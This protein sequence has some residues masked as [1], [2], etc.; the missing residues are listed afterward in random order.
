MLALHALHVFFRRVNAERAA[1]VSPSARENPSPSFVL[2]AIIVKMAH[3]GTNDAP[4]HAKHG[5][6][7]PTMAPQI[8]TEKKQAKLCAGSD[9]CEIG[10]QRCWMRATA[11]DYNGWQTRT[12]AGHD[13]A[14]ERAKSTPT[15]HVVARWC[16]DHALQRRHGLSR[17]I[18]ITTRIEMS[19]TELRALT[20]R[21]AKWCGQSGP[22]GTT[23]SA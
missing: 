19:H 13:D 14:R 20:D 23:E 6:S 9:V 21:D 15:M 11:C 10:P 12:L 5:S 1:S 22:D 18:M 8:R 17:A 16:A 7:A 2:G 4:S 3:S